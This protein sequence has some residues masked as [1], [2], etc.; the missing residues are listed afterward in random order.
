MVLNFVIF[1]TYVLK[2]SL[3]VSDQ[4]LNISK[5][6]RFKTNTL[7]FNFEF[8]ILLLLKFLKM[9]LNRS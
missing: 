8:H 3:L 9:V 4:K 2:W 5:I 7:D 1:E 6:V